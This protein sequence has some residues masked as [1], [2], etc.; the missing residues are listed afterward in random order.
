M[1]GNGAGGV[2]FLEHRGQ[3]LPPNSEQEFEQKLTDS[4]KDEFENEFKEK[5]DGVYSGLRSC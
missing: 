5:V 2:A 3:A 1:S 4:F